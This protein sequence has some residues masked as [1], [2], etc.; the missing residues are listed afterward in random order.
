MVPPTAGV[1]EPACL[2]DQHHAG[3]FPRSVSGKKNNFL[4]LTTHDL[5]FVSVVAV[6]I[7]LS[8]SCENLNLLS[9]TSSC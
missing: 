4:L 7:G 3:Y 6:E 2:S 9:E 1:T 8:R 5:A